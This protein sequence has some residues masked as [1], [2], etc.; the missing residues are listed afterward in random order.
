MSPDIQSRRSFVPD[1]L[2]RWRRKPEKL[3][4]IIEPIDPIAVVIAERP[5]DAQSMS[6]HD[7]LTVNVAEPGSALPKYR[8][9]GALMR[10]NTEQLRAMFKAIV[11]EQG[12][13]AKPTPWT[14]QEQQ[15]VLDVA[16]YIAEVH[17][18]Q[19]RTDKFTPYE[20]HLLRIA[21]R[22][23][24]LDIANPYMVAVALLH[25]AP[26]DHGITLTDMVYHFVYE[27]DYDFNTINMLFEG[28][29]AL[30]NQRDGKDLP[31][32]QYFKNIYDTNK[33]YP[34]LHVWAIKGLDRVDSF[35]SDLSAILRAKD[36]DGVGKIRRADA[37]KLKR[38][39][40]D[41][42]FPVR[43]L[44]RKYEPNSGIVE[45]IDE[46]VALSEELVKDHKLKLKRGPVD[47]TVFRFEKLGK[48]LNKRRG[49]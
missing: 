4:R 42:I 12:D 19:K 29:N 31:D 8:G 37:F 22:A 27:R 16:E 43:G 11:A 20:H 33:E 14:E 10:A 35:D 21:S 5:W 41:K 7:Q 17:K 28:A 6:L 34:D 40:E 15:L 48:S 46:A 39:A 2:K 23:A 36:I 45:Q 24:Q 44:V 1:R 32:K 13:P 47:G 18:N 38:T 9:E 30:N 49:K 25:D 3:P 26:E